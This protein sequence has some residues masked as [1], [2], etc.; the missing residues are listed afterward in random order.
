MGSYIPCGAKCRISA[1]GLAAAERAGPDHV[2]ALLRRSFCKRRPV[3][4]KKR[5]KL[6]GGNSTG[7]KT[8][9]GLEKAKLNLVQ[10]R[11]GAV[12]SDCAHTPAQ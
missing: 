6:H 11:S 8:A 12:A 1:Q 9:A 2:A 5:C 10:Y 4:G 7:A 3:P